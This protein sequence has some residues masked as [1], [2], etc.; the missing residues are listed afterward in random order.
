MIQSLHLSCVRA[1]HYIPSCIIFNA[2]FLNAGRKCWNPCLTSAPSLKSAYQTNPHKTDTP[3][4]PQNSVQ[5]HGMQASLQE[6]AMGDQR[7]SFRLFH[8]IP[9]V[10]NNQTSK[11]TCAN[12][13]VW[14]DYLYHIAN[15][16]KTRE[17]YALPGKLI[18]SHKYY[19]WIVPKNFIQ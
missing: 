16:S 5:E 10:P 2:L 6:F 4:S 19:G 7:L 1:Q 13:V 11:F 15:N 9:T 14:K 18:A 12:Q 3:V 17:N 8:Q